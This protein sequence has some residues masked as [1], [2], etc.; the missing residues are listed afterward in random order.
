MHPSS[1]EYLDGGENLPL[2]YGEDRLVLLPRDP[3]WLF[4]YWEI[5]IPTRQRLE[6]ETQNNWESFELALRV[7]R[8]DMD[9]SGKESHFDIPINPFSDNWYI[10]AGVPDK[11][12]QIEFGYYLPKKGFRT[13]LTSNIVSTPRDSLSNLIDENWQLPDWQ[14]RRLYRR[15]S[16]INL[17]SLEILAKER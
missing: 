15:I 13:L 9:N 11:K 1:S 8:L 4:T 6:S 7:H 2:Y 16:R 3:Y 17:S 5:S 10:K 14:A 12:Y